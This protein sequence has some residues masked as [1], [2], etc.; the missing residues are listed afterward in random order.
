M[1]WMEGLPIH[2]TNPYKSYHFQ[3]DGTSRYFGLWLWKLVHLLN[4]VC[5]FQWCV[6]C[7]WSNFSRAAVPWQ[8]AITLCHPFSSCNPWVTLLQCLS[9]C[10]N[11]FLFLMS[12]KCILVCLSVHKQFSSLTPTSSSLSTTSPQNP[13]QQS[14]NFPMH[15]SH[16]KRN[17]VIEITKYS[18]SCHVFEQ[19]TSLSGTWKVCPSLV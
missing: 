9:V 2:H 3:N 15:H 11:E 17:N 19:H 16:P 1:S 8:R 14:P 12:T 7:V 6:S 10:R 4:L 5:S 18:I 13:S